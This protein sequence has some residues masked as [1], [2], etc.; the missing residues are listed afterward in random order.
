MDKKNFF[1]VGGSSGI[2]LEIVKRL[3]TTGYEVYVGSRNDRALA[4]LEDVA[5]LI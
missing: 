4:V 1:V 5:N 2:G 3:A